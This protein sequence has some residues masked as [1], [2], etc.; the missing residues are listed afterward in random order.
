[1][2]CGDEIYE[3]YGQQHELLG[4]GGGNARDDHSK[5]QMM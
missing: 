5:R 4:D 3:Q 1:M 2:I